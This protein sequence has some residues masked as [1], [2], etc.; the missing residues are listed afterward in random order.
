[1]PD[2]GNRLYGHAPVGERCVEVVRRQQTSNTTLN[3]LVSLN[4]AEYYNLIDG[5]T[6]TMQFLNFFEEAANAV[7]FETRR[8]ALEVG[9]SS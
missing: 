2:V 9:I 7:N 3:L 4:G 1:M 6:D 5:A 8:P